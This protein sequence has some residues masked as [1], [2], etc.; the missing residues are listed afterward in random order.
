MLSLNKGQILTELIIAIAVAAIMVVFGAQLVDIS[1]KGS[2]SSKDRL[3]AVRL[4]QESMEALRAIARGNDASSQGWNRIYCPPDG[5]AG[6][7]ASP[8]KGL[9]YLYKTVISS[10][11][12]VLQS[13]SEDIVLGGETY[14]RKVTI[15][16]VCRNDTSGNI[17]GVTPCSGGD[18]EDPATQ[19]VTV[20]VTKTG[21][22]DT[23]LTEYFTRF[24]NETTVQTDWSGGS[25]GCATPVGAL[26][27]PNFGCNLTPTGCLNISVPGS[28][29]LASSC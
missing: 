7:C 8:Q 14:T 27:S 15:E 10:G 28:I 18:S 6:A 19:K 23:V 17:T 3:V 2:E 5:S 21:A 26:T 29:K 12:W 24:G 4:A 20:T 1:F 9:S 13:G 16:N 11:V 22:P 25:G